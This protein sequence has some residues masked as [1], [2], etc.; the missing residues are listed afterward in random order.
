MAALL[1]GRLR[2]VYVVGLVEQPKITSTTSLYIKTDPPYTDLSQNTCT[3]TG[4]DNGYFLFD[5]VPA[6]P[7]APS[8]AVKLFTG[9]RVPGLVREKVRRGEVACREKQVIDRLLMFQHP[10]SASNSRHAHTHS[11]TYT[12]RMTAT[13]RCGP[14]EGHPAGSLPT[15][16]DRDPGL[17]PML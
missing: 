9:R 14:Q 4:P 7:T 6:E 8:T 11:L 5:F 13:R 2:F 1:V 12:V 17:L 10:I 15:Q 16:P 3:C